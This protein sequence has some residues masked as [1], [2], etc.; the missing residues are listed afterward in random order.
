MKIIVSALV[1]CI[2]NSLLAQL[3][4]GEVFNFNV[5]DVHQTES[6]GFGSNIPY[7]QL[8]S[9][10]SKTIS[11]NGDSITYIIHKRGVLPAMPPNPFTFTFEIDTL[12]ITN[13][14]DFVSHFDYMSCLPPFITS[15]TN[16]CGF[17]EEVKHSDFDST[18]FE[19]PFW[20]SKMLVG[21]G[22]PYYYNSDP[23]GP[24]IMKRELIY[25]NTLAYGEC[26]NYHSFL[27]TEANDLNTLHLKSTIVK[28]E[29]EFV[30]IQNQFKLHLFSMNGTFI[31]TTTCDHET[32][33]IN[34]ED[35]ANGNYLVFI[36][37]SDLAVFKFVKL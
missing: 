37:S 9:I 30:G 26:G 3:T 19:P 36:E 11:V 2:S 29:L 16:S 13:L 1:L 28:N 32:S 15:D 4:N 31:K 33:K 17:I 6:L 14:T 12:V 34:I 35:L 8:D 24:G 21:L 25:S 23:S 27:A 10:K 7:F 5:N 20:Y 18:C 22:G